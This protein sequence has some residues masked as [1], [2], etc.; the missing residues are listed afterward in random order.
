MKWY[1]Y[2][3][4]LIIPIFVLTWGNSVYLCSIFPI[5]GGAIGGAI[6]ALAMIFSAVVMRKVSKPIFK[7]LIGLGFFVA[8]LMVCNLLAIAIIAALT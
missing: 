4:A 6:S 3:L 5:V 1:E 8:T 2:I 7:I